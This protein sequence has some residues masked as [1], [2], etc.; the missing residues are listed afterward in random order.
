MSLRPAYCLRNQIRSCP[1]PLR[2]QRRW[3]RVHDIRFVARHNS[4]NGIKDRYQ[5]KLEQKAREEGFE[6]VAQ[7]KAAYEERIKNLRKK[8]SSELAK[9]TSPETQAQAS[10]AHPQQSPYA[11]QQPPPPPPPPTTTQPTQPSTT[12]A[13]RKEGGPPIKPLSSYLDLEKISSLPN[14]EIEYL[15]RL[16]HANDPKSLCALVPIETYRRIYDTAKTHPRFIL[17]LPRPAAE[18]GS[19]DLKQSAEGFDSGVPRTAS[20]I[21]FLQ[22][23]FHPPAGAPPAPGVQTANTHTSTILFTHLAAYKL[24]GEYAQ[25]HT[26]VTHH[27]DLA[28]SHGLVLLNGSV[29]DGRGKFYDHGGHGGGVGKEKRQGLLKKFTGGD[30]SFDLNE[31]VDEAER[32]S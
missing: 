30:Q 6:S 14:K 8:V 32:I 3:A 22:W 15:W 10:Q 5:D 20:D 16:R 29:L 26:T 12:S 1:S 19:G 31:L 24:H 11:G 28:D 18:D 13:K 17:P 21:H 23:S 7:L 9:V 2:A 27:L 25:P 4:T